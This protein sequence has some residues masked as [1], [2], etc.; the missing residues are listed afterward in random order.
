MN[1]NWKLTTLTAG[2][3]ACLTTAGAPAAQSPDCHLPHYEVKDLGVLGKGTNATTTDMNNAG[4]VAGSS[5]L[6]ANGPQHAFLW[7]GTGPLVDLGTL[8]GSNS[9]VDG[10]NLFGEGAVGSETAKMDP[11]GEDFCGYQTKHQ[12]LGAIWRYGKLTALPTLPGAHNANAFG[13]NNLGEV[14]GFSETNV[15]DETCQQGTPLQVY[16]YSAVKWDPNGH[17]HTLRPL[18][19]DTVSYSFGINDRGQ[20]VGSSG[21]CA[22][23]GLPPANVGGIHA[24]LWE[25]DGIPVNLP[26]PAGATLAI[27]ASA[28][29][30]R[31]Q[32][33]A[34]AL[35][36]DS[37]IRPFIWSKDSG[38][39][40]LATMSGAS[41]TIAPCCRTINNHG[42]VVGF[43][44]TDKGQF[45]FLW[46]DG[47]INDLNKLIEG[48]TQ[49]QVLSANSINDTGE[50]AAQACILPACTEYHA[51]RL[52]PKW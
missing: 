5:N 37:T 18:P 14:V 42:E 16:R 10:P 51:V 17:I 3:A 7:Y 9:G 43:Y 2:L 33:V 34:N 22:T 36:P 39:H 46:K 1:R 25:K 12:C 44:F 45:P 29:N 4:W 6:F 40:A 19:G 52:R 24:V 47:Q 15:R 49:F 23:E 11:D 13:L 32:V 21:T 50:I 26:V 20:A 35:Y 48:S 38:S 28:V 27:A 41:T 30:D 31:G 8:G